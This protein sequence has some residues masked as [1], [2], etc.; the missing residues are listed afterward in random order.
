MTV[1]ATG[2]AVRGFSHL[3]TPRDSYLLAEL[4]QERIDG[5]RSQ[6][7]AGGARCR[8]SGRSPAECI[9][10]LDHVHEVRGSYGL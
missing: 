5:A 7:L 1:A 6:R 4:E 9:P 10:S 3:P 8:T 2:S